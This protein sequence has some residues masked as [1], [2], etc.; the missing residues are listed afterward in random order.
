MQRVVDER[1]PQRG[2]LQRENRTKTPHFYFLV[3]AVRTRFTQSTD[4]LFSSYATAQCDMHEER[5]NNEHDKPKSVASPVAFLSRHTY[6]F[7]HPLPPFYAP[8]H[9]F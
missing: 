6:L 4:N 3:C 7:Q 5:A 2:T 9:S 8:N 1:Q